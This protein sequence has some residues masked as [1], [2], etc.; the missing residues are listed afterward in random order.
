MQVVHNKILL[1]VLASW[2]IAQSLKVLLGYFAC[3]K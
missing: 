1:T 3:K 2:V